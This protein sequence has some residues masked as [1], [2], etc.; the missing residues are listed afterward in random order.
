MVGICTFKIFMHGRYLFFGF[1]ISFLFRKSSVQGIVA[2]PDDFR[3]DPV[4]NFEKVQIRILTLIFS[5]EI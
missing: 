3:P 1:V 4:P 5:A 2:D